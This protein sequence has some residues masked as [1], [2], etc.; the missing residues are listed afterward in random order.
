M[1]S[2]G[3]GLM[4]WMAA[5]QSSGRWT[6]TVVAEVSGTQPGAKHTTRTII[7]V[8]FIEEYAAG[9]TRLRSVG[10]RYRME[11]AISGLGSCRGSADVNLTEALARSA[12]DASGA[13]RLVLERGF[14]GW[15]CGKNVPASGARD[16]VI[17]SRPDPEARRVEA[18]RMRGHYVARQ[19]TSDSTYEFTVKWDIK[20]L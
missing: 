9:E 10:S 18:G 13:Y 19:R 16:V 5:S 7:H 12:V 2:V 20:R 11:A 14:F 1:V 15:A 6:G 17:G 8:A 3:L 4:L